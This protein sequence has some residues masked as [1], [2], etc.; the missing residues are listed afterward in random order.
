MKA[1]EAVAKMLSQFH[2]PAEE[3]APMR[4]VCQLMVTGIE[5]RDLGRGMADLCDGRCQGCPVWLERFYGR[6]QRNLFGDPVVG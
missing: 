3:S 2:K 5:M 1:E 4:T 6:S